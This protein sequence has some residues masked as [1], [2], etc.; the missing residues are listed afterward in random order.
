MGLL[1]LER[2]LFS[3]HLLERLPIDTA[4]TGSA[5]L[6]GE[7]LRIGHVANRRIIP[8]ATSDPN[9]VGAAF[10]A[11]QGEATGA[12]LKFNR[13]ER[14]DRGGVML[15]RTRQDFLP[16]LQLIALWLRLGQNRC[17]LFCIRGS[18]RSRWP[19]M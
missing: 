16:V 1:L 8:I 11:R 9:P 6:V 17:R 13:P 14:A 4:M 15:E 19:R 12:T 18:G 10:I 2:L 5:Q 3:E 7:L